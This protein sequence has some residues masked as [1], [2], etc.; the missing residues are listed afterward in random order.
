MNIQIFGKSKCFDTKKAERYFK[1][2]RI[3]YQY[4]DLLRYGLSGKEFD[5]VLRGVGGVDQLID[6]NSS[7][8]EI[9]NMRYMDDPIAKE[10]KIFDDPKLMRTPIVRNGK[11]VTVGYC[12]EIWAKWE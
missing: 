10:D 1:E 7:S 8:Q 9:T 6:W 11:F 5:A 12:P 4:V 2:R 3:K